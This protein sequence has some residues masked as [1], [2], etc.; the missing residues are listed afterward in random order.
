VLGLGIPN[1]RPRIPPA[2]LHWLVSTWTLEPQSPDCLC[3]GAQA[4][5]LAALWI[6]S[7]PDPRTPAWVLLQ[8]LGSCPAAPVHSTTGPCASPTTW[9]ARSLGLVSDPDSM[10][11]RPRAWYWERILV[12][13]ADRSPWP[14][15]S[16]QPPLPPLIPAFRSVLSTS[17]PCLLPVP[18]SPQP[19]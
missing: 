16:P 5:L 19:P 2:P 10:V 3:A 7:L 12:R 14:V 1:T 17:V 8:A 4:R 13:G 15:G 9:R 6:P 11:A 18:C